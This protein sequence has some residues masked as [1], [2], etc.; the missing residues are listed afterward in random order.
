M[1]RDEVTKK[2]ARNAGYG[3]LAAKMGVSR[4][5]CHIGMFDV[6]QCRKVVALCALYGGER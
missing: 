6:A 3:W 5:R 4:E 2:S 1:A